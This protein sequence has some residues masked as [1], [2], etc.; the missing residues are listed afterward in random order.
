MYH[1][2]RAFTKAVHRI[3]KSQKFMPGTFV[4]IAKDLGPMMGHFENNKPAMINYT[5]AQVY[6]GTNAKSYGIRIR[7]SEGRW[8]Y[9]AWYKEHQLTEIKDKDSIEQYKREIIKQYN[10]C[11]EDED[12]A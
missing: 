4:M 1:I 11:D 5:Y 12:E 6:D 8:H 3:P 7:D 10:C 9:S 2:M